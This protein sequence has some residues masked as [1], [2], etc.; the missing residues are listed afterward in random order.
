[1]DTRVAV[2][3]S[4]NKEQE[5]RCKMNALGYDTLREAYIKGTFKFYQSNK[6]KL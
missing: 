6:S 1:M 2:V 3:K 4:G 5:E